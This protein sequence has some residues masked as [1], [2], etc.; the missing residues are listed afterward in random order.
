MLLSLCS[1]VSGQV[2]TNTTQRCAPVEND[3]GTI[4]CD[5][6][7][8]LSRYFGIPI[9][10]DE[11]PQP[12]YVLARDAVTVSWWNSTA[13]SESGELIVVM[14]ASLDSVRP[15]VE[16]FPIHIAVDV[17]GQPEVTV[18]Q[19]D[20]SAVPAMDGTPP[21]R[22]VNFTGSDLLLTY[23]SKA[24][25]ESDSFVVPGGHFA[26]G[27]RIYF[28]AVDLSTRDTATNMLM[29]REDG[30]ANATLV[31]LI[32][33]FIAALCCPCLLMCLVGGIAS[34]C[35]GSSTKVF[36]VL[37]GKGGSSDLGCS[38]AFNCCVKLANAGLAAQAILTVASAALHAVLA[39]F[40]VAFNVSLMSTALR[41][42]APA[43]P[44]LS[45]IADAVRD[46]F[47]FNLTPFFS[48]L[49][50]LTSAFD[51]LTTI[52][53][54]KGCEG[55]EVLIGSI[56]LLLCA[57]TLLIITRTDILFFVQPVSSRLLP[58]RLGETVGSA[59]S[60]GLIYAL[61]IALIQT[62]ELA[63]VDIEDDAGCTDLDK[64]IN[65]FFGN[66]RNAAWILMMIVVLVSFIYPRAA[67]TK[68]IK[69]NTLAGVLL[70][71]LISLGV[72][73][74]MCSDS[75][76]MEK[77]S[78]DRDD[79]EGFRLSYQDALSLQSRLSALVWLL[80]PPPF[81]IVGK[82]A[83]A[84][85]SPPILASK[86]VQRRM[87]DPLNLRIT[88]FVVNIMRFAMELTTVATASSTFFA[89]AVIASIIGRYLTMYPRV[90][91]AWR[92]AKNRASDYRSS[93][94][95]PTNMRRQSSQKRKGDLTKSGDASSGS[96]AKEKTEEAK[97][98]AAAPAD[99]K[100]E[101]ETA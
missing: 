72:W 1:V 45:E 51:G 41:W 13:P 39:V 89:I 11:R 5:D 94:A 7:V 79:D 25:A 100:T 37:S 12:F 76:E 47:T 59:I 38:R 48:F 30:G 16:A 49:D 73:T 82:W 80:L 83:E 50:D 69:T 88:H 21:E 85:A 42:A 36:K 15:D 55:S 33:A 71:I 32:F 92:N 74:D 40:Q 17:G 63:F 20:P 66:A 43:L 62:F 57:W 61:Q 2:D 95:K 90:A 96:T 101:T 28:K 10:E 58:G 23:T 34:G 93:K 91:K 31:G 46:S 4:A 53:H 52:D 9:G 8:V 70:N 77:R 14:S 68:D 60:A 26:P 56:L 54:L 67:G 84:A 65:E 99:A 64:G 44:L 19:V 24:G 27:D 98:A 3:S 87:S 97:S 6:I 75:M 78:S 22:D 18:F 81:I 86:S 35:G 29:F